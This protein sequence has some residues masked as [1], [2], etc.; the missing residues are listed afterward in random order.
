MHM[1]PGMTDNPRTLALYERNVK[2]LCAAAEQA[3]ANTMLCTVSGNRRFM[4]KVA[5]SKEDTGPGINQTLHTLAPL[6]PDVFLADVA[7]AI[8]AKSKEGLP[9][10][11]FFVDNVHF[12]FDGNYL[13]AEAMF[14]T[15]MS[16]PNT[17]QKTETPL[18]SKE[19]CAELLAWTPAAEFDLLGWQLQAFLDDYSKERVQRRYR[20]LKEIVGK[21]W[22]AQLLQDYLSALEHNPD[23]LYLRQTCCQYAFETGNLEVA[24]IQSGEL[25]KRHPAARSALRSAGMTAEN[26]GNMDAA[27]EAYRE[28]LDVY[29]DDPK[30]LNRL[31]ELLFMKGDVEAAAPLYRRYLQ[32]DGT[33]AFAWCR[34]GQIAAAKGDEGRA[35]TIWKDAIAQ[36]PAHPLA[37]RLLDN[38]MEEH[39]TEQQRA[40]FWDSMINN[41]P[42]AAEPLVRR[43]LLHEETDESEEALVLLRRAVALAPGDPVVHYHLGVAAYNAGQNEEAEKAF[44]EAVR[45]NPF[46]ERNAHWLEKALQ[47]RDIKDARN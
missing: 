16:L 17:Q 31:A 29:P 22:K 36:T 25:Q 37:Y 20:K 26:Q 11:D 40:A 12:N 32:I 34:L 8:A 45:L 4:G 33:D 46:D 27:I 10:Y 39:D 9:G 28:C 14:Q 2:G 24:A 7:E 6:L 30:A 35:A 3:K 44:R 13:A 19:T 5:E 43:A 23:D 1:L 42:E 15:L 47:E 38:L 41:Y 21:N 18:P